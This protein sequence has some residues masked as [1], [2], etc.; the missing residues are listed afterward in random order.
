MRIELAVALLAGVISLVA[1][2]FTIWGTVEVERFKIAESERIASEKEAIKYQEPLIRA[3][4]DL[5]S[6]LYNILRQNL[7]EA[8]FVN[9]DERDKQYVIDNTVFLV[10]QY[11]SWSEIIR[12]KIRFINLKEEKRTRDLTYI[13]DDILHI[14]STDSL[15]A[16]FRIFAGEQRAIGESLI[17][18]SDDGLECIGYGAFLKRFPKGSDAFIDA[19]RRHVEKFASGDVGE[20]RLVQLQHRFIDLLAFLD[21]DFIRFPEKSRSKA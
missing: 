9:G 4:Y 16:A 19:I 13:F 8:Y 3:A 7:L 5:Q 1:A 20:E 11:F 21:P 6:R 12:Q 18:N 10:A 14:W 2:G 17:V 15:G